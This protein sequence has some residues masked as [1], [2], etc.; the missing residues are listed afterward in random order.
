[1]VLNLPLYLLDFLSPSRFI[2]LG[3]N[4]HYTKF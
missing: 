4:G 2:I 1:L 3:N